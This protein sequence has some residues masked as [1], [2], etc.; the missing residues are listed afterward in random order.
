MTGY[1]SLFSAGLKMAISCM[2]N[3]AAINQP[4]ETFFYIQTLQT[5]FFV[6][7]PV[8]FFFFFIRVLAFSFTSTARSESPSPLWR[9]STQ[10]I[11]HVE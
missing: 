1:N 5:F 9:Q 3:R 10:H 7:V 11:A 4:L 2:L 8:L 6:Y